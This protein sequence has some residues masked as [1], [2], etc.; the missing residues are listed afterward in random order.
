VVMSSTSAVSSTAL[1][2][3]EEKGIRRVQFDDDQISMFQAIFRVFDEDGDGSITF[4]EFDTFLK[5]SGT[6]L[7]EETIFQSIEDADADG[8]GEIDFE[9]FLGMLQR[10]V[11]AGRENRMHNLAWLDAFIPDSVWTNSTPGHTPRGS[12]S[13]A[14]GSQPRAHSVS[15]K[16]DLAAVH[17]YSAVIDQ[18]NRVDLLASLPDKT[19]IA[20]AKRCVSRSYA[21]GKEIVKQGDEGNE[22]FFIQT[23]TA[24]IWVHDTTMDKE[25]KVRE[26]KGQD[27]AYFG[28]VALLE[29]TARTATVRAEEEV[30]CLVVDRE[31]F[32][33][34]VGQN[35]S[36]DEGEEYDGEEERGD[37][38]KWWAGGHKD[39][40]S[41]AERQEYK[42]MFDVFDEDGGGSIELSE[43]KSIIESTETEV[44]ESEVQAMMNEVDEDGNGEIDLEEFTHMMHIHK[45]QQKHEEPIRLMFALLDLE[46]NGAI[47]EEKLLDAFN[48]MPGGGPRGKP[49][50]DEIDF[51][52]AKA[53]KG[54]GGMDDGY[55]TLDL[56]LEMFR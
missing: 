35:E 41:E 29:L 36:E 33:T 16:R 26:L 55:L 10:R 52:L 18:L 53:G 19:K 37:K 7:S 31:S 4:F 28:E 38:T 54:K 32:N 44:K 20:L 6:K 12:T 25:I 48:M 30:V 56:L 17:K 8:N 3:R 13:S 27:G 11:E 34:V 42:E 23:G 51:L 14:G 49:T 50:D 21:A 47:L 5:A 1:Q 9:E 43:L 15:T 40:I 24:S 22:M 46:G 45:V 2:Q 39:A